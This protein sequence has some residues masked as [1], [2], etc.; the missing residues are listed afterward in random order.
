MRMLIFAVIVLAV[1]F[2]QETIFYSF[3]SNDGTYY[4]TF[5]YYAVSDPESVGV[6]AL[7]ALCAFLI[8]HTVTRY[9]RRFLPRVLIS[10]VA[11]FFS[12]ILAYLPFA[13]YNFL[14]NFLSEGELA[15]AMLIESVVV[16][17]LLNLVAVVTLARTESSGGSSF[18]VVRRIIERSRRDVP[19]SHN[20]GTEMKFEAV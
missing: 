18:A 10:G 9:V 19:A 12:G 4:W 16:S 2:F 13:A 15:R 20:K 6:W 7:S 1:V 5:R 14:P 17:V 11:L 8:V 3:L